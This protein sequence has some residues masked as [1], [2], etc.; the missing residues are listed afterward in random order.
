MDKRNA[1]A[2]CTVQ[3]DPREVRSIYIVYSWLLTVKNIQGAS[4]DV[5]SVNEESW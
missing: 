3:G 5:W 2:D 4:H 1:I